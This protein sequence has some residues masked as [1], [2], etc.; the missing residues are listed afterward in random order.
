MSGG[1]IPQ[2][3]MAREWALRRSGRYQLPPPQPAIAAVTVHVGGA[4]MDPGV[5]SLST[6]HGLSMQSNWPEGYEGRTHDAVQAHEL[7]D[8]QAMSF[9]CKETPPPEK[10]MVVVHVRGGVRGRGPRIAQGSRFTDALAGGGGLTD[11]ADESESE[12]CRGSRDGSRL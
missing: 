12:P 7:E 4:V 2:S 9:P 5:Y 10:H 1:G 11:R 6:L 8:A 3:L